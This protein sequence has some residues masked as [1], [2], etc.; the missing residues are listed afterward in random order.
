M[1]TVVVMCG[2][3]GL[4]LHPLTEHTP[5]SLIEVG[6][7]PMLETVLDG[8]IA[9]GFKQFVFCEGYRWRLIYDHFLAGVKWG[10]EIVHVIEDAPE[11][12]AGAL[13]NIPPQ[14]APFI[15]TNA[16]VIAKL[17]YHDLLA[18]HTKQ[19]AL[20]T[21]CLAHYPMQVPYGVVTLDNGSITAMQEKPIQSFI[22]NAGIYVL[23]PAVIELIHGPCNMPDVLGMLPEGR[24]AGYQIRDTWVDV[25][26][27]QSLE[28]ARAQF[29]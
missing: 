8:F 12:T 25:G 19:N 11:G 5:K 14:N 6:G 9:Q 22:V 24:L 13:R 3:R 23:D 26:T 10:V 1:T 27:F 2:G 7:K 15:V 18:F 17:D 29:G 16:D 20:A 21:M 28:Q 4:R